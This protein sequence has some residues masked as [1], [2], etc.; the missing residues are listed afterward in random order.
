M[1]EREAL[2]ERCHQEVIIKLP[3]KD[4]LFLKRYCQYI[5]AD[6]TTWLADVVRT[7]IEE[8]RQQ[9]KDIIEPRPEEA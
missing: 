8:K 6:I 4:W 3:L 9:L 2:L 7:A 1:G 5:G